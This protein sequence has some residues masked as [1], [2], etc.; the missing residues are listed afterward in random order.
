MFEYTKGLEFMIKNYEIYLENNGLILL[1][2]AVL[3]D[4][5]V[6]RLWA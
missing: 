3:L 4:P 1:Y 6:Q 5:R 2:E